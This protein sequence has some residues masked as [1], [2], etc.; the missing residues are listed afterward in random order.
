MKAAPIGIFALSNI[1]EQ[2]KNTH[3]LLYVIK[4]IVNLKP[5]IT[6]GYTPNSYFHA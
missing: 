1:E 6:V 5:H 4:S 3:I 2:Y